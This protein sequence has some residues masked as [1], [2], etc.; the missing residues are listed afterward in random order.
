MRS[1]GNLG[2]PFFYSQTNSRSLHYAQQG[3]PDWKLGVAVC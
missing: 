2:D 1:A 3:S